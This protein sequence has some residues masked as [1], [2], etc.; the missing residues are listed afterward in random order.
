MG[1][2]NIDPL[3]IASGPFCGLK[4]PFAMTTR[5]SRNHRAVLYMRTNNGFAYKGFNATY[6]VDTGA[7]KI[8][9]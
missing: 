9:K 5:G 8:S 7:P 6:F 2:V 4:D 3:Y 1:L